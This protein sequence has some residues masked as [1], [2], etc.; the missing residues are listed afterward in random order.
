MGNEFNVNHEF[1]LSDFGTHMKQSVASNT[2]KTT[3]KLFI[4]H[5]FGELRESI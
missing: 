5:G 4:E 3:S 1:M 2:D